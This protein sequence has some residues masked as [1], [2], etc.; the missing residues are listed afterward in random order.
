MSVQKPEVLLIVCSLFDGRFSV[1]ENQ[2][3][4]EKVISCLC[5]QFVSADFQFKSLK[6]INL[7]YIRNPKKLL[8]KY[9]I[10]TVDGLRC[11]NTVGQ[12][13]DQA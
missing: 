5:L 7:L 10:Q 13:G 11:K 9:P 4:V 1:A 12:V 3:D 6:K 8:N 2:D